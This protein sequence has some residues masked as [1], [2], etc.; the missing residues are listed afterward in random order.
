MD[1]LQGAREALGDTL[2]HPVLMRRALQ[3]P[4]ELSR[5]TDEYIELHEWENK[6]YLSPPYHLECPES[7]SAGYKTGVYT[8][9]VT[10]LLSLGILNI[11]SRCIDYCIE[12]ERKRFERF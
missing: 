11:I 9:L 4:K 1:F 5:I 2:V 12:A 3:Y 6:N 8:G 7:Y 10:S